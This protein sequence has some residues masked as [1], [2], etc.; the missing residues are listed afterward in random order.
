MNPY[1]GII[2]DIDDTRDLLG[3]DVVLERAPKGTRSFEKNGSI[4]YSQYEIQ[5]NSCTLHASMTAYSGLTGYRFTLEERKEIYQEALNQGFDPSVGWYIN[6][7]VHLI[8]KYVDTRNDLQS[9]EYRKFTVGS[10]EFNK[11]LRLGYMPILGYRGNRE[12]NKDRN[13]DKILQKTEFGTSSY[14]HALTGR[15]DVGSRYKG[16][17]LTGLVD[18]YPNRDSNQYQV[19]TNHWKTLVKNDVFFSNARIYIPI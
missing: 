16:F 14:G 13:D 10:P 1:L 15:Y 17:T 19:P 18:N 3:S 7:A 8:K 11:A 2:G 9:V 4:T 12:F 5:K 6:K